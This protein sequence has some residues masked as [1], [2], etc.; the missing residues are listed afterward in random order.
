MPC[1]SVRAVLVAV[2]S[3]NVDAGM[4]YKTDAAISSKVKV[5]FAVPA[6]SGPK[7]SYPVAVLKDAPQVAAAAKFL[8]FL[9]APEADAVFVRRGFMLPPAATSDP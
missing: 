6:G 3:S 9:A 7:I 1:E 5:V 2:E 4:V 8:T